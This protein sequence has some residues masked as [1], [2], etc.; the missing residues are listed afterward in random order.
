MYFLGFGD[1]GPKQKSLFLLPL[2]N[3]SISHIQVLVQTIDFTTDCV[4]LC[5]CVTERELQLKLFLFFISNLDF[6]IPTPP[7]L[8]GFPNLL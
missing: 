4:C 2:L 8:L 7:W 1:K 6:T 3:S 5:L